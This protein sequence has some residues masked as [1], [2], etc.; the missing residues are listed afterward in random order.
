MILVDANVLIDVVVDEPKW[1]AWSQNQLSAARKSGLAINAIIYSEIAPCFASKTQLDE[2]VNDFS[3]HLLSISDQTA[4]L[5]FIAHQTYRQA[6]GPR[7]TTLPDFF[8]GAQAAS[9]GLT[10]LT[11][12]PKRVSSYFPQVALICPPSN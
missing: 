10:L 4:Y 2:F 3:L 9:D 8:I 12:D 5:A 11:R 7:L 1:S 6:G